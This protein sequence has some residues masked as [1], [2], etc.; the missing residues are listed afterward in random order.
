MDSGLLVPWMPYCPKG[1]FS[2]RKQV[3]KPLIR[4]EKRLLM[5]KT[6]RGVGVS[7]APVAT[8]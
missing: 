5:T 6:P 4:P 1:T 2:P 7:Q 8:V 3:P